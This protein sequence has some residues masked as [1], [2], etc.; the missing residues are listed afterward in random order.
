VAYF[1]NPR[2]EE[3]E[4]GEMNAE[5]PLSKSVRSYLKMSQAKGLGYDSFGRTPT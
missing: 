4:V 1:Y 3:E 2:N 5:L